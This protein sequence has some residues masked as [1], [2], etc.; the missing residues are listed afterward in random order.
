MKTYTLQQFYLE[1]KLLIEKYGFKYDVT[2]SNLEVSFEI[3]EIESIPCLQC[4]IILR[5][6]KKRDY[7]LFVY[8]Q[9]TPQ[10]ALA[11]LEN[12]LQEKTG[13]GSQIN[14]VATEILEA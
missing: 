1:A 4:N 5:T 3:E 8:N 14:S 6:N 11:E 10:A 7:S 2:H 13:R 9:P 12:T